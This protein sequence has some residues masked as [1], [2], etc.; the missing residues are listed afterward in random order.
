MSELITADE[1]AR[2]IA[3]WCGK[4]RSYDQLPRK[5]KDRWILLHALSRVVGED[6]SLSEA[7]INVRIEGWL[8]GI[9]KTIRMDPVS[10][11]RELIDRGFLERDRAG[12][13]YRVS[14]RYRGFVTI[15]E[16]A[17]KL[18]LEAIIAGE[19]ARVSA[20]RVR[21]SGQQ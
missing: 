2:R 3:V 8:A 21:H 15:E 1:Y 12:T 5:Q 18:D 11:R 20:R 19:E 6:E 17:G 9:G 4:G 16:A 7:M 10:L 13:S 14:T